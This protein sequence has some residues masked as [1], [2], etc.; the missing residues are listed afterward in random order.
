MV[1]LAPEIENKAHKVLEFLKPHARIEAAYLFGSYAE[2]LADY[3]S[4]ID[5]AVFWD[6]TEAWDN[7]RRI[8]MIINVQK[9]AGDD[10]ELHFFQ[11]KLLHSADPASFA[12]YIIAH[13][14]KI[15]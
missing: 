1:E 3:W 15:M 13:G 4:D 9:K 5:I 2:G 10:I 7:R 6:R 11:A 8:N 14:R 12:A